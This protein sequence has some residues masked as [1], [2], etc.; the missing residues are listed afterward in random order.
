MPH[1]RQQR[2]TPLALSVAL[3]VGLLLGAPASAVRAIGS[4]VWRIVAIADGEA[5]K[6]CKVKATV[7][8][9]ANWPAYTST[10][11]VTFASP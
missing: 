5:A 7:A 4:P 3:L 9:S 2:S 8:A 1:A 11:T 6:T 10:Y